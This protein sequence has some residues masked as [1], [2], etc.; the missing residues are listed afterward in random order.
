MMMSKPK[1]LAELLLGNTANATIYTVPPNTKAKVT[2]VFFFNNSSGG[3]RTACLA[4]KKKGGSSRLLDKRSITDNTAFKEVTGL[5]LEAGDALQA[6]ASP[7]S[8]IDCTVFGI[9][10]PMV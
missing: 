5:L 4:C 9:E 7:Q 6:W 2:A 8:N 1:I 3:A 10:Y